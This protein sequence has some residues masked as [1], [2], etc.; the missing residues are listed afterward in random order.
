[1]S[2]R[3]AA[4]R[5]RAEHEGEDH[6]E[7]EHDDVDRETTADVVRSRTGERLAGERQRERVGDPLQ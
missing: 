5:R 6:G 4:Q 3:P 7:A 1:M 2:R